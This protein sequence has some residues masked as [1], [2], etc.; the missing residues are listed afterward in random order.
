[1]RALTRFSGGPY[2]AAVARA[3]GIAL[4]LILA[5][6][7]AGGLPAAAADAPSIAELELRVAADPDAPTP[8]YDLA[9]AYHAAGDLPAAI[10][11]YRRALQLDPTNSLIVTSLQTALE[12]YDLLRNSMARFA[13]T[14]SQAQDSPEAAY[15]LALA[16]EK[17]G[18]VE[19]A[20]FH[21]KRYVRDAPHAPDAARVAMRIAAIETTIPHRRVEIRKLATR[22]TVVTPGMPATVIV[23]YAVSGWG[24]RNRTGVLERVSLYR[25]GQETHR[26]SQRSLRRTNKTYTTAMEILVPP[27]A[28]PGS[29]EL[30]ADVVAGSRRASQAAVFVIEPRA[31]PKPKAVASPAPITV[32][33]ERGAPRQTLPAGAFPGSRDEP[34]VPPTPEPP[35]AA[36]EESA[37]APA[38]PAPESNPAPASK[39]APEPEA[40]PFAEP[41]PGTGP[42]PVSFIAPA[43]IEPPPASGPSAAPGSQPTSQPARS[44]FPPDA[45]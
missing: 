7:V 30:V 42:P 40:A 18:L 12:E 45:A 35:A 16:A 19:E 44:P 14:F 28:A 43:P 37:A 25:A 38:K 3:R 9:L 13:T 4:G 27:D 5:G 29:Y 2:T 20:L 41:L 23:S 21:Y 22:P 36:P 32:T 17:Q 15:N 11:Q 24:K 33:G 39:P 10:A 34:A 8:A 6:L 1:M 26:F 31:Q